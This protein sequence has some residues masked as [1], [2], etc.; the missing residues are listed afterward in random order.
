MLG[1]IQSGNFLGEMALLAGEPRF[2]MA[3][4]ARL[5][6]ELN[7]RAL[8]LLPGHNIQFTKNIR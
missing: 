5:L 6:D 4:A 3:A 7:Q 2:A 1:L 8:R